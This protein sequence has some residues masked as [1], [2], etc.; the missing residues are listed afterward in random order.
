MKNIKDI[1]IFTDKVVN[2]LETKKD[3]DFNSKKITTISKYD[4]YDFAQSRKIDE[5]DAMDCFNM[6][7]QRNF[8]DRNGKPIKSLFGAIYNFCKQRKNKRSLS[9][10]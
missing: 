4:V 1:S 3:M 2:M 10:G 6:N 5:F 9:N 8:K 7:K